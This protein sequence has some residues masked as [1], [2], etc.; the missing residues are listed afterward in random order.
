MSETKKNKKN[1]LLAG[2]MTPALAL[3]AGPQAPAQTRAPVTLA[4]LAPDAQKR[5]PRAAPR[6][7][8]P[9]APQHA[10]RPMAPPQQPAMRAPAPMG[11]AP[12]RGAP[13][14]ARSPAA[15]GYPAAPAAAPRPAPMQARPLAQPQEQRQPM[16]EPNAR[17][18][19]P[20]PGAAPGIL[21]A[22]PAVGGRP[23][24]PPHA[25]AALDEPRRAPPA[26][27]PEGQPALGAAKPA[28][29][30]PLPAGIGG[31]GRPVGA[32]PA[33][34][35][36]I[37]AANRP[38]APAPVEPDDL[39][40]RAPGR[41]GPPGLANPPAAPVPALHGADHLPAAPRQA[42]AAN[43]APVDG[44]G[45][46]RAHGGQAGVPPA[47]GG[48]NPPAAPAG[49]A[50]HTPDD[51]VVGRPG[52]DAGG[53]PAAPGAGAPAVP[54]A[55]RDANPPGAPA[56]AARHAPN[57]NG[58]GRPGI[59]AGNHMGGPGARTP[60]AAGGG[61]PAVPPTAGATNE[62]GG[63]PFLPGQHRPG[64]PRG[65][66]G[67]H[68]GP[69]AMGGANPPSSPPGAPPTIGAGG[70]PAPGA[71]GRFRRGP[72]G[73]PGAPAPGPAT[74]GGPPPMAPPPQR[75][76][77]SGLSP[78]AAA[79]IG[80][81]AGLV[82]GFML[83]QPGVARV[84]QIHAHRRQFDQDGYTVIEEPG[85]TIVRDP[86]GVRIRHDENERFRDLGV[87]LRSERRGDEFVTVYPRRDGGEVVTITDA[88]GVLIR[89][90][91][92]FPDGREIILIDN[93]FRG[94][95]RGFVDEVV[96]LPP[97]P[98]EI[99]RE[100]YVV[101]YGAADQQVVYEALTAPPVAPV[102]R[103][104]TLDE[105]RASPSLRAYT[106]SVDIDTITFDSGSWTV[107]PDQAQRLSVIAAALNEAIRRNLSEVYLI[108]GHTDA[109]GLDVDNLSLSDRRAQAVATLLT[110]DFDV[111]AENLTTQ[112]YGEQ[113]PKVQVAGPSR[114]NRRVTVRR[115]TPLLADQQSAGG[116]PSA[117]GQ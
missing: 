92:R 29:G 76:G 8:A 61:R 113:Y 10:P 32:P 42:P 75:G 82:G 24:T 115:I 35:P 80:A 65:P 112:G 64:D 4:Q 73:S 36:A 79:A 52:A 86:Y 95:P 3:A 26:I 7:P 89:R 110:R 38:P 114:E 105:V 30:A 78:A 47:P 91:R 109:V 27:R 104:Y 33:A 2:V 87:D 93:S 14:A 41:R 55:A 15:F 107:A 21:G 18:Q 68:A 88:N 22:A 45:L 25:P 97:P 5:D 20:G 44:G 72:G 37:G 6:G 19:A 16:R 90:I 77:G 103:R 81:A 85:R 67:D 108:E 46:P 1:A 48:A 96:V 94:P 34:A 66:G 54:P 43:G 9:A 69:P 117:A 53:Q 100:R 83:A 23:R 71:Y 11:A 13:P 12:Q 101:D 99:P 60:D 116:Q 17:R 63:A 40:E 106:R 59:G 70:A 84:D 50:R 28:R 111:P 57:D 31:Q 56:G 62:P 39:H 58:A 51:H 98:V 74:A 102:P 49:A